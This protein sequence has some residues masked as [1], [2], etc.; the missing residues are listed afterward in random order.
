[1]KIG[2]TTKKSRIER[3]RAEAGVMAELLQ[4]ML[5]GYEV[6][7]HMRHKLYKM[8]SI[9]YVPYPDPTAYVHGRMMLC[10]RFTHSPEVIHPIR[11]DALKILLGLCKWHLEDKREGEPR[12]YIRSGKIKTAWRDL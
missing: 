4:A 5:L 3:A 12:D 2:K 11:E 9:R 7:V 8:F 10:I 1:M 6:K